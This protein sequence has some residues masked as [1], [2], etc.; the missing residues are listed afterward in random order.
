[1]KLLMIILFFRLIHF[2]RSFYC[3]WNTG[4]PYKYLA[5][6]TPYN[7]VRGDIR[8]SIVKLEGCEPASIW[9]IY[10]HGKRYP[11]MPEGNLMKGGISIKNYITSSYENGHSGMCAQD[12][13]NLRNWEYNDRVFENKEDLTDEG[14]KEMMFLGKRFR[15]AFPDLLDEVQKSTSTF[16]SAKGPLFENSIKEL[17]RGLQGKAKLSIDDPKSSFDD[18]NPHLNCKK[19]LNEVSNNFNVLSEVEKY[20]N[21][22][23]YLVVSKTKYNYTCKTLY[24]LCRYTWSGIDTRVSP[25]CAIFTKDDLQVLEYEEDLQHYFKNGYGSPINEILGRIPLANLYETFEGAKNGNGKRFVAYVTDD[26]TIEQIYSAIG[27][28]KDSKPLSG[29][30]QDHDRK[31]RSS[32]MSAFSANFVAVLH[33]CRNERTTDY[34]VVFYMNEEPVI[35]ICEDGVCSWQEFQN[36]LQSFV[37][38]TFDICKE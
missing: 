16:R 11:V 15:E 29:V 2:G 30:K 33:R 34:N 4:C 25:W 28:F 19:Y 13:D 32:I 17:V 12:V 3:Y 7:S 20:I 14:R 21:T 5:S 38:T 26:T 24:N 18:I 6:E 9:G 31:W 10:R 37:N 27:L 22:S 23:D 8:D 36:K 35:S 1:M